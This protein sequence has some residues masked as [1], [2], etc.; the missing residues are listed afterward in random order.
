MNVDDYLKMY[1][2]FND[3]QRRGL[4]DFDNILIVFSFKHLLQKVL[5]FT[6]CHLKCQVVS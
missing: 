5:V 3:I 6:S 1:Y 2:G 4:H